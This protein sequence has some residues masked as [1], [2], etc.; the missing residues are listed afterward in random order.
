VEAAESRVTQDLERLAVAD[1]EEA[2]GILAQREANERERVALGAGTEAQGKTG[3]AVDGTQAL[4]AALAELRDLED[5]EALEPIP[6]AP[7]NLVTQRDREFQ[8]IR[9]RLQASEA[10]ASRLQAALDAAQKELD[11]LGSRIESASQGLTERQGRRAD[12]ESRIGVILERSGSVEALG[13]ALET[14]RERVGAIAAR[15]AEKEEVRRALDTKALQ[16]EKAREEARRARLL[17]E[18]RQARDEQNRLKGQLQSGAFADLDTESDRL[19]AALE[20]CQERLVQ[21]ER[22]SAMLTLLRDLFEEEQN[23]MAT[24][25]SAPLQRGMEAYL[26]CILPEASAPVLRYDAAQGFHDLAWRREDGVAWEFDSLSGGAREQLMAALRLA[27]AEVLAGVEGRNGDGEGVEAGDGTTAPA[28][29][30]PEGLPVVFDDSFVNADPGRMKGILRML[31]RAADR[32]LQVMVFTC[33]P[34]GVAALGDEVK[35]ELRP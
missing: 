3:S 25:F 27:M 30:T 15:I 28:T 8:E 33:D 1:A 19:E 29:R 34:A 21:L 22:E 14:A 6:A 9:A 16:A 11:A 32:G 26:S 31:E 17:N 18:E 4:D 23:R 13:A 12:A 7:G 24:E 2:A 10:E 5:S 20:A 35:V